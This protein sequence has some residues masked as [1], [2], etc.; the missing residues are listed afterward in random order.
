MRFR[1]VVSSFHVFR[2]CLCWFLGVFSIFLN[3][4]YPGFLS[5]VVV[6]LKTNGHFG[7]EI[8]ERSKQIHILIRCWGKSQSQRVCVAILSRCSSN[9]KQ[10]VIML[11]QIVD[12]IGP[13]VRVVSIR[14]GPHALVEAYV[15]YLDSLY[16]RKLMEYPFLDFHNFRALPL[17]NC[18]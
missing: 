17:G 12:A 7:I 18:F 15:S 2:G 5:K 13:D 10:E 9:V 4:I 8:D 11:E 16:H 6:W 3:C 14:G 1:L